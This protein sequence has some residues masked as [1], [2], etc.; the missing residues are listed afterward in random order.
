MID[1]YSL[2]AM[3][4]VWS[5]DNAFALWLR[6]EIAAS[7]AWADLGIVPQED[8]DLIR[9]ATFNRVSYDKWFD[10]TKHDVVSFT[11]A[12]SESLGPESRWIHYGL[13]SNDVKDTALAMQMTEACDLVDAGVVRLMD[14]LN[15]QAMVYKDTPCIGRSHGVHA[16][17]MSFGLKLALWWSEM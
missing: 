3:K 17:P 9:H 2:P 11:R 4:K 5:D 14:A 7:Q 13:T 16:E 8:M 1:R 12:V 15:K 10:E 6:V